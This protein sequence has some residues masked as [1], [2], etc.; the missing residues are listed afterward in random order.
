MLQ[1]APPPAQPTPPAPPPLP[2]PTTTKTPEFTQQPFMVQVS[3]PDDDRYALRDLIVGSFGLTG[4]LV[5]GGLL[6]GAIVASVLIGWRKLRNGGR[7]EAPPTL[8]QIPLSSSGSAD[9]GDATR[10]PSSQDQ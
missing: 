4:A 8:G 1:Q 7:P 3:R 6:A 2:P 10:P 9:D 5:L